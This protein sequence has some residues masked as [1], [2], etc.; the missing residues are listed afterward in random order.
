MTSLEA[1]STLPWPLRTMMPVANREQWFPS[2]DRW[3]RLLRVVVCHPRDLTVTQDW[4][5]AAEV[6]VRRI[7]SVCTSVGQ[8]AGRSLLLGRLVRACALAREFGCAPRDVMGVSDPRTV[9]G[10]AR[11]SGIELKRRSNS[12]LLATDPAGGSGAARQ[13]P[14]ACDRTVAGCS[15]PE[16]CARSHWTQRPAANVLLGVIRSGGRISY[17]A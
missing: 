9:E 6:S 7:R 4:A 17:A 13:S 1:C 8:T 10:W 16:R 15:R 3:A 12:S 14:S 5:L 11:A 2:A